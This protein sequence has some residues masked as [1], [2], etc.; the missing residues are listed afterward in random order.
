MR[1]DAP[2][3]YRLLYWLCS[4]GNGG[5]QQPSDVLKEANKQAL[6][7]V[8][9]PRSLLKGR[10]GSGR[11]GGGARTGGRGAH[12]CKGAGRGKGKGSGSL[13]IDAA[14][15]AKLTTSRH[16]GSGKGG[17]GRGSS[18][19]GGNADPAASGAGSASRL[20]QRR[21][22]LRAGGMEGIAALRSVALLDA[23]AVILGWFTFL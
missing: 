17:G 2:A 5:L 23:P 15:A 21:R 12:G 22:S 19:R 10:G 9:K 8:P 6:R 1:G 7:M 11:R 18:G 14:A 3:P 20:W 16:A 13:G 4:N